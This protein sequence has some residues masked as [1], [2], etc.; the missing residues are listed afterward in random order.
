MATTEYLYLLV[1]DLSYKYNINYIY[2][3]I[4]KDGLFETNGWTLYHLH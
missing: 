1:V 3:I 2:Y 4:Q